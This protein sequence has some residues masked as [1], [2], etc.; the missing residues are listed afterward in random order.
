MYSIQEL[1]GPLALLRQK[2][3]E[4]QAISLVIAFRPDSD[5]RAF[6]GLFQLSAS[7]MAFQDIV[8]GCDRNGFVELGFGGQLFVDVLEEA[9]DSWETVG[10]GFELGSEFLFFVVVDGVVSFDGGFDELRGVGDHA[11]GFVCGREVGIWGG[12]RHGLWL[13]KVFVS[14]LILWSDEWRRRAFSWC[15]DMYMCL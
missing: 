15:I 7:V 1:H 10:D 8:L 9:E 13:L 2:L 11:D 12:S 5:V 14:L 6:E 4:A 3:V